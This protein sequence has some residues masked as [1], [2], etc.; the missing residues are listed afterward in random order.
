[1]PIMRRRTRN[2]SWCVPKS[3]LTVSRLAWKGTN[4][5]YRCKVRFMITLIFSLVFGIYQILGKL[6]NMT[7][8]K[9]LKI[10]KQNLTFPDREEQDEIVKIMEVIDRERDQI[11]HRIAKDDINNKKD[12]AGKGAS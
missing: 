5:S 4:H 11:H 3:C 12:R 8:E 7:S 1:M 10:M 9:L 2:N 6:I